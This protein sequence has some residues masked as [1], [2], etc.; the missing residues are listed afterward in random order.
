MKRIGLLLL[1]LI[2]QIAL[3]LSG[4]SST[5]EG[6][7]QA[8]AGNSGGKTTL[9]FWTFNELHVRFYEEAVKD[10]NQQHP[11]QQI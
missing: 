7:S 6:G 10:W 3:V 1:A 2:L 4:C 8:G 5:T 11:D 9:T